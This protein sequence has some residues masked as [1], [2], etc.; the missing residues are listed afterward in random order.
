MWRLVTGSSTGSSCRRYWGVLDSMFRS[1][2]AHSTPQAN[3]FIEITT[4]RYSV[5]TIVFLRCCDRYDRPMRRTLKPNAFVY[6][7]VS[8]IPVVLCELYGSWVLADSELTSCLW[9]R[10]REL[11]WF[12]IHKLKRINKHIP[13]VQV[14]FNLDRSSSR[15][16]D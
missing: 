7:L 4:F 3:P 16:S 14:V 5:S 11:Q 6:I 10:K 13:Q 12:A 2:N 9:P 1:C 15:C 8:T